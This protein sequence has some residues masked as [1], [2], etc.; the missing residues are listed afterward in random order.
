MRFLFMA[1]GIMLLGA[2]VRAQQLFPDLDARFQP[3]S[4]PTLAESA[5]K[6][7]DVQEAPADSDPDQEKYLRI[8]LDDL[9]GV[10]PYAR[11]LSYCSGTATLTNETKQPLQSLSL[12]LT[13]GDMTSELS[14][15][16][17][18]PNGTQSRPIMLIGPPCESFLNMPEIEI[19]TCR[20]GAHSEDACKKKVKFI[21]PN[22]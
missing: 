13:Y 19:K 7:A 1:F 6:A 18:Q 9:Q 21:P 10:L 16:G 17:V 3:P 4:K 8:R 12:S 14:Y 15:G 5:P 11:T 22:S 2:S 20:W